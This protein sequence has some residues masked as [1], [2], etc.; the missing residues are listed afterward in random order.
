[1]ISAGDK[2]FGKAEEHYKAAGIHLIEARDRVKREGMTFSAFIVGHCNLGR[3]RAYELIAIAD[4]TKTL[5]DVRERARTGMAAH[6]GA[7]ADCPQRYGQTDQLSLLPQDERSAIERLKKQLIKAKQ[8]A[9]E[10]EEQRQ[11]QEHRANIAVKQVDSA[12][13]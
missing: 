11:A 3:S 7:K 9:E 2:A 13:N 1:H 5:A 10:K 8:D 12:T 6:R 4:G